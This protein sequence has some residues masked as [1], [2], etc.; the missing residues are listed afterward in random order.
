MTRPRFSS[1]HDRLTAAAYGFY[2]NLIDNG[3]AALAAEPTGGE[4][5]LARAAVYGPYRTRD[6]EY[7]DRDL[8]PGVTVRDV[9]AAA[10][11]GGTIFLFAGFGPDGRH[12][13]GY[14]VYSHG[15]DPVDETVTVRVATSHYGP[16]NVFYRPAADLADVAVDYAR[17]LPA[18]EPYAPFTDLPAGMIAGFVAGLA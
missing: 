13:A 12:V 2:L 10:D 7:R 14:A 11:A 16:G 18:S 15:A 3:P 17:D 6:P 4:S 8:Y 5:A 9:A 1:T